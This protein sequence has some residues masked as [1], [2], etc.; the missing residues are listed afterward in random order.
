M[1]AVKKKK[2]LNITIGVRKVSYLNS[3]SVLRVTAFCDT[4]F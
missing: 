1:T 2:N 3:V 4:P